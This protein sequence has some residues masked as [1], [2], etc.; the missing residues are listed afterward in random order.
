M[1]K[2]PHDGHRAPTL[3]VEQSLDNA[4]LYLDQHLDLRVLTLLS[5]RDRAFSFVEVALFCVVTHLEF[6]AVRDV[7][8]FARLQR[9]LRAFCR[10]N[11]RSRNT[12]YRFDA[13]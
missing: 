9:F 8:S 2:L 5:P 1:A 11:E 10:A 7:A 13:P 6:R 12:P 4:L 3:K